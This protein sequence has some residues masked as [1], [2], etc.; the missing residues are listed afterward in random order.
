[1]KY[2]DLFVSPRKMK[3]V[4]D[5]QLNRLLK[6]TDIKSSHVPFIL[7]IGK[8]EGCSMKDLCLML[9]TDKG[10]VTRVVQNLIEGEFVENKSEG[11]RTYKLFLTEKGKKAFDISSNVIDQVIEDVIKVLDEDEIASMRRITAKIEKK[12]DDSYRY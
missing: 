7:S 6:D 5:S 1:M 2:Q 11:G 9:G 12:L 3:S 8:H 4:M 10:L